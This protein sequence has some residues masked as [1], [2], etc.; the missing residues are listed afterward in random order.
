[1]ALLLHSFRGPGEQAH[2]SGRDSWKNGGALCVDYR[3]Y[4]LKPT[5]TFWDYGNH[6]LQSAAKDAAGDNLY[7]NSVPGDGPDTAKL[8]WYF[9]VHQA[10]EHDS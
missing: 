8:K 10:D 5:R 7:S 6:S 1:V 9:P 4:D 2:D 3:S